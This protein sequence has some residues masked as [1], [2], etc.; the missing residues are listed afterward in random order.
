M[1]R[2]A[3]MG[4]KRKFV[5]LVQTLNNT[6][7]KKPVNRLVKLRSVKLGLPERILVEGILYYRE[8]AI[9][10]TK[11][12]QRRKGEQV[13]NEH[14][15]NPWQFRCLAAPKLVGGLAYVIQGVQKSCIDEKTCAFQSQAGVQAALSD[16]LK[17]LDGPLRPAL[18]VFVQ[19]IN[20]PGHI[21][22]PDFKRLPQE[23]VHVDEGARSRA[24]SFEDYLLWY[25]QEMPAAQ[26]RNCG[27][28][29]HKRVTPVR[30][31]SAVVD[32]T[33]YNLIKNGDESLLDVF[34]QL[35]IGKVVLAGLAPSKDLLR[36]AADLTMQGIKVS[37]VHCATPCV[38]QASSRNQPF[39]HTLAAQEHVMDSRNPLYRAHTLPGGN[40][41]NN[42]K[43]PD[44]EFK[45]YVTY[46]PTRQSTW[47]KLREQAQEAALSYADKVTQSVQGDASTTKPQGVASTELQRLLTIVDSG[48]SEFVQD[49]YVVICNE[50]SRNSLETVGPRSKRWASLQRKNWQGEFVSAIFC[51]RPTAFGFVTDS[52]EGTMQL[53]KEMLEFRDSVAMTLLLALMEQVLEAL[54][55]KAQKSAAPSPTKSTTTQPASTEQAGTYIR[56]DSTYT[57][58]ASAKQQPAG[59]YQEALCRYREAEKEN[60][61]KS[62]GRCLAEI[63]FGWGSYTEPVSS[64]D[65]TTS[66]EIYGSVRAY[67][68]C[69]WQDEGRIWYPTACYNQAALKNKKKNLKDSGQAFTEPLRAFDQWAEEATK[70]GLQGENLTTATQAR[71]NLCLDDVLA[72]LDEKKTHEQKHPQCVSRSPSH[73]VQREFITYAGPRVRPYVPQGATLSYVAMYPKPR[74]AEDLHRGLFHV[75]AKDIPVDPTQSEQGSE[76]VRIA[77]MLVPSNCY[78][79]TQHYAELLPFPVHAVAPF[80]FIQEGHIVH[81]H[82]PGN[83]CEFVGIQHCVSLSGP[84]HEPFRFYSAVLWLPNV[85]EQHVRPLADRVINQGPLAVHKYP[86]KAASLL[87]LPLACSPDEDVEQYTHALCNRISDHSH[88]QPA[89]TTWTNRASCTLSKN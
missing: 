56:N 62:Q 88:G 75:M 67:Q 76:P 32:K 79:N 47:N 55:A 24:V 77:L 83:P 44:L 12:Y 63:G 86:I 14:Y 13:D 73:G 27:F 68:K 65:N 34:E 40:V 9:L 22:F 74:C 60:S 37:V 70:A 69:Y 46:L 72:F 36:T 49:K 59:V 84:D 29:C 20:C 19:K 50:G 87:L 10:Q 71:K 53:I 25:K 41:S 35:G 26:S 57:V 81:W 64:S 39:D 78:Y 7:G 45:L 11:C 6:C 61:P 80:A 82:S 31:R 51:V 42:T 23:V 33:G 5:V 17:L 30:P 21:T 28:V 15:Q 66:P 54:K 89:V 85:C 16:I 52:D 4:E 43:T 48:G 38:F 58:D 1:V 18:V 8:L 3:D 2:P